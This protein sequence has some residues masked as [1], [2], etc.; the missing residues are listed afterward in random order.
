VTA[1]ATPPRK[2]PTWKPS[3]KVRNATI[4]VIG[5]FVILAAIGS[6]TYRPT[7]FAGPTV[8]PDAGASEE[9]PPDPDA[10]ELITPAPSLTTLFT[11]EGSGLVTSDPFQASGDTVDVNYEYTCDPEGSF[12]I[13][14]YG[15]LEGGLL[16]DVLVSEFGATGSGTA[17]ESLNEAPGPFTVEVD[18]LCDWSVEV[19]G[20][21]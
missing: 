3:H 8:P 15:T 7:D 20:T 4:G 13:S 12:T 2:A 9:V 5:V 16:P 17:S 6:A 14:F 10:T 1:Q 18:S 19:A 21:P 11:F